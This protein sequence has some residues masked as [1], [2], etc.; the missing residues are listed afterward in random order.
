MSVNNCVVR[1]IQV[2]WLPM[3]V[4]ERQAWETGRPYSEIVRDDQKRSA[5]QIHI[6]HL[7]PNL[8]SQTIKIYGIPLLSSESRL[9]F[10][11][12]VGKISFPYAEN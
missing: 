1:V 8:F 10:M 7:L 9:Y 4:P 12:L 11:L 5:V 2:D 6:P 3:A